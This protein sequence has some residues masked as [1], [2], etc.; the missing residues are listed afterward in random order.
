LQVA[1][2]SKLESWELFLVDWGYN[3]VEER[4]RA[5]GNPRIK[6]IDA[7]GFSELLGK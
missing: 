5:S 6:V 4:K 7:K 3:T 1:K 2:D